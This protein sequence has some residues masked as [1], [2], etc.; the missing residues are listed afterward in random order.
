VFK[1][2]EVKLK[3]RF[4]LLS[5]PLFRRITKWALPAMPCL[6]GLKINIKVK[7]GPVRPPIIYMI[8]EVAT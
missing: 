3:M 5:S 7:K 1:A 6:T 8:G 2:I 4:K